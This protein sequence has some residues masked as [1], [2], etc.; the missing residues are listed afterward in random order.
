[1][2]YSIEQVLNK[3]LQAVQ[4]DIAACQSP[5]CRTPH[6]EQ[7]QAG[8]LDKYAV[9]VSHL[10][11]GVHLCTVPTLILGI[12]AQLPGSYSGKPRGVDKGVR[13]QHVVRLVPARQSVTSQATT[14]CT[15]KAGVAMT[16]KERQAWN[17]EQ[18]YQFACIR[19]CAVVSMYLCAMQLDIA[20]A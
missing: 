14:G 3:Q 11:Q 8:C 2:S 10:K 18:A 6:T 1:M 12:P 9:T 5:E 7:G 13:N 19:M 20:A 4:C 15:G 17:S 16:H